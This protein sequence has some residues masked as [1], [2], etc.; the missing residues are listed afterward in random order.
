MLRIIQAIILVLGAA[1]FALL[2]AIL[3]VI[4]D[5][6]EILFVANIVTVRMPSLAIQILLVYLPLLGIL[7]W[8][9][10]LPDRLRRR[11][12]AG[13]RD[14]GFQAL[15]AALIS[16]AAGDAR[17]ARRSAQRAETLLT[18]QAASR[19]VAAQTALAAG[20]EVDAEAHYAAMLIE[21][22]THLVGRRGLAAAAITRRDYASALIHAKT[23]FD[24][25]PDAIWAFELVFDAQI[26][27]PDWDGALVTLLEGRRRGH[28]NDIAAARR[29][30]VILTAMAWRERT[31]NVEFARQLAEQAVA[32]APE[33]TPAA[34]LGARL[35]ARAGKTK[36][37]LSLIGTAWRTAPHPALASLARDIDASANGAGHSQTLADLAHVNPDHRESRIVLAELALAQGRASE[38]RRI[39][40]ALARRESPPSSRLCALIAEAARAEGA[41]DVAD[42]WAREAVSAPGEAAWSDLD[43]L[44]D[45]F[46]FAD[47]DWPVFV[48][49]YGDRGELPH[50]RLERAEAIRAL[51]V[52]L[53]Q[54]TD[55]P[56]QTTGGALVPARDNAPHD[57]RSPDAGKDG[58]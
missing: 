17:S 8:L 44:G 28:I 56:V 20:D 50:P 2:A 1:L 46:A 15:E 39:L 55:A 25:A 19:L 5:T 16:A 12:A 13:R 9:T 23:A 6:E 35:L 58:L 48:Y 18:A 21:P 33:F 34:T 30:A 10:G 54:S 4:D 45:D 7:F 49:T 11:M 47:E 40:E 37:A 24:A 43:P 36:R 42:V 22:R 51:P 52:A 14:R 29:R 38:A 27:L 31:R 32:A 26:K 41:D 3:L 57:G 53:V